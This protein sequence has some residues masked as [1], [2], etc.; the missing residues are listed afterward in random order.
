MMLKQR[1][2]LKQVYLTH[3]MNSMV[4]PEYPLSV[5]VFVLYVGV[6]ITSIATISQN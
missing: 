5:C 1:L 6:K 2:T 4:L 3:T